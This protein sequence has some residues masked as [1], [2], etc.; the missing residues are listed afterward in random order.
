MRTTKIKLRKNGVHP[1]KL[2]P[3]QLLFINTLAADVAFDPVA[4]VRVC[5][6][7]NRNPCSQ[8]AKL[9]ANSNVQKMLG[10]VLR[11]RLERLELKADDVLEYLRFALFFNPLDYFFPTEDGKW[12]IT[13]LKD[14][15]KEVGRLIDKMKV[16]ERTALDGSVTVTFE[17]ELVSKATSLSLAMKHV[18]VDGEKPPV[19]LNI[20][21]DSLCQ[22][23]QVL[24]VVGQRLIEESKE[25]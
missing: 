12:T 11:K 1:D 17:I 19:L 18:G 5:Y 21:W 3:S 25:S 9:M 14:L 23:G 10:V 7:K 20:D 13:S 15:P 16:K 8:A 6:P 2:N 4:A 22:R 24:D